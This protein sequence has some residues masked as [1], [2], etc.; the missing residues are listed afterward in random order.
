[1]LSRCGYQCILYGVYFIFVSQC[2]ILY[3]LDAHNSI[4]VFLKITVLHYA[5][6]Y[7][8]VCYYD[9][10]ISLF[11]INKVYLVLII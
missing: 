3:I 6:S 10:S 9:T 2:F 7:T 5:S 11:G 8:F 1:M 4:L